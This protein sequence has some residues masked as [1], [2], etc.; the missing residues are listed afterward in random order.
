MSGALKDPRQRA[1]AAVEV[2]YD[3]GRLNR[4]LTWLDEALT[5]AK[6]RESFANGVRTTRRRALRDGTVLSS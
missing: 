3:L 2:A 4:A 6:L 1:S 5:E